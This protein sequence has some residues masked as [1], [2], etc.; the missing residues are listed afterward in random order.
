MFGSDA[1]MVCIESGA[2]MG[3]GMGAGIIGAEDCTAG[4]G[5]ET[6]GAEYC[7]VGSGSIAGGLAIVA[8]VLLGG[9]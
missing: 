8:A 3:A 2:G 5:A 6:V 7:N 9:Q 4:S 1:G